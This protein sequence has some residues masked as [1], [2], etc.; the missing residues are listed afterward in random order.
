MVWQGSVS[1]EWLLALLG[2]IFIFLA[3][4]R[5]QF[6]LLILALQFPV[7][8]IY[9]TRNIAGLDLQISDLL[10][11]TLAARLAL[12]ALARPATFRRPLMPWLRF[13]LV[14]VLWTAI[15]QVIAHLSVGPL[16]AESWSGWLRSIS[17]LLLIPVFG[18]LTLRRDRLH[19]F[20]ALVMALVVL[21]AIFGLALRFM[22]P[23][24]GVSAEL[25][26]QFSGAKGLEHFGSAGYAATG[27]LGSGAVFG[28]AMGMLLPLWLAR[29][30]R[31]PPRGT[32]PRVWG[33]LGLAILAVALV[34]SL[35][36]RSILG[37]PLGILIVLSRN[38]RSWARRL[39]QLSLVVA[40]VAA[41]AGPAVIQRF[42]PEFAAGV[43]SVE[44][45]FGTRIALWRE[46][47]PSLLEQ[48]VFGVGWAMF[49]ALRGELG[50]FSESL[51]VETALAYG[52]PGLV[53]LLVGMWLVTVDARYLIR[54]GGDLDW[55]GSGMLGATAV[56][57]IA[58]LFDVNLWAD[59]GRMFWLLVGLQW[60]AV[61]VVKAERRIG[62]GGSPELRPSV[63]ER[64]GMAG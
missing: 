40:L 54:H 44:T 47:V 45:S 62:S 50:S 10:T 51:Y 28:L 17:Y 12:V 60:C 20:I 36:R 8:F 32:V 24:L 26:L 61:R 64:N 18:M 29:W 16:P 27:T 59:T 37:A 46:A 11:A 30:L 52:L 63:A 6:V 41:S 35:S 23:A 3:P 33:V 19:R 25:V 13:L 15:V 53:L 38:R 4:T 43:G 1:S 56:V 58:G 22:G 55:L 42:Q 9:T 21:Q 5:V 2:A 31:L 14:L 57:A 39:V 34:F 7:G 49:R 48:P